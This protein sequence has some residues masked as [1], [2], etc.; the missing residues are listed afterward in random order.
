M[1][2]GSNSPRSRKVDVGST[3]PRATK[4]SVKDMAAEP[5]VQEA[6]ALGGSQ[7]PRT[8]RGGRRVVTDFEKAHMRNRHGPQL[9]QDKVSRHD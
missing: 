6:K 4:I 8:P 2:E 3:S 7:T 5:E 9:V 1:V